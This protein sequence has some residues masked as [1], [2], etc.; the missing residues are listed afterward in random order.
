MWS[1]FTRLVDGLSEPWV[2][3]NG[4]AA[5]PY[6]SPAPARGVLGRFS[7]S[8]VVSAALHAC[9]V[10]LTAQI[11]I[12]GAPSDAPQPLDWSFEEPE[13]QPV[14]P[15]E[16]EYSMADP[17]DEPSLNVFSSLALSTASIENSMADLTSVSQPTELESDIEL[18]M[19]DTEIE[20]F[21]LDEVIVRTGS[22]GEQ[23]FSVDGAVDRITQEI[24]NHLEQSKVLVV[25][26]MD[27]SISLVT[28]RQAVAERMEHV[29]REIDELGAAKGD[30]LVSSV[31]AFGQGATQLCEPTSDSAPVVQAIRNV[32][33]DES[34]IENVF[35]T[36]IEAI[37]RYK[38]QRVGQ[39]RQVMFVVWTDES[40]NDYA[41]LED[42][43]FICRKMA[44]PVYIVGPSAM[45]GK[46]QGT[47]AYKHKDGKTYQ[48]P[49]DRGPDAVRQEQLAIPYWFVGDQLE[50]LHSGLG[51]FALSRLAQETGGAYFIKDHPGD[52]GDVSLEVMRRYMPEYE[53]PSE[54]VKHA[55]SDP[56]RRAVLSAVDVTRQR[57]IKGTPRL[58]FAPTGQTYFQELKE[59]QETV[60][61]NMPI[62]QQA[63]SFF[64]GKSLEGAWSQEPAA[65]WRAWHDLTLGRLLAMTVRCNEYNWACATMKAKGADFVDQ[66]S[67]RWQFKPD[68]ELHFGTQSERQAK[69]AT[70]LL[71]R[72]VDENPGTPWAR[73]AQ[74]ELDHPLGFLVKE[75]YV[76]PPPEPKAPK[77]NP[78]APP[79]PPPPPS[80]TKRSEQLRKLERPV[81]VQLPKL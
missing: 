18:A 54:Y 74:R 73:L 17:D 2:D 38:H 25:W 9:A 20:G 69:E 36:I 63:L 4:T 60:A 14:E 46:E 13:E 35:T 79:P 11:M 30:A 24:A 32:P 10:L 16:L 12:P 78:A 23:V 49:V 80:K 67:N 28:D 39:H 45:F 29:Y 70:R 22:V 7:Q 64:G 47:M 75:A 6:Q 50:N 68:K 48:L 66:K 15:P 26:M 41:R 31:V 34:G 53:S 5:N 19:P 42:A 62:L 40:G 44:I 21:E 77:A 1:M 33:T 3:T 71:R 43:V 72:C 59:A 37:P 27:A 58:V 8:A 52:Q 57:K 56:L 61:Y 55:Q 76:A 81:E 65:R 51:P